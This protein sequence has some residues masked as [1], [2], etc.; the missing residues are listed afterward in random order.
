MYCKVFAVAVTLL[1]F[2]HVALAQ[3]LGFTIPG[4][5][6]WIDVTAF[7][8]KADSKVITDGIVTSGLATLSSNTAQFTFADVNKAITAKGAGVAGVDLVT[9]I[10]VVNTGVQVTLG[11]SS[12]LTSSTAT[13]RYST[14]NSTPIQ[15]AINAAP[16]TG[17]TIYFPYG[18]TGNYYIRSSGL[19]IAQT[20][21]GIKLQGECGGA[22]TPGGGATP[23]FTC[24]SI[25]TDQAISILTVGDTS[26]TP[27][28]FYAGLVVQ[29]LGFRDVSPSLTRVV[30]AIDLI[31][32][33][34]FNLTNIR[35]DNITAGYGILF[36][37]NGGH[38]GAGDYTQF[39]VVFH[40]QIY[41]TKFPIQ[42][43]GLTS[44]INL[45]G[46]NL[47]CYGNIPPGAASI[48]AGSIGIDIGKTHPLT[49]TTGGEWGVFGTHVLD[50]ATGV[51]DYN[52]SVMQWF[53]V[54][55]IVSGSR[56]GTTGFVVDGDTTGRAGGVLIGGSINNFDTDIMITSFPRNTKILASVTQPLTTALNIDSAALPSTLILTATDYT[57]TT[58]I[59]SQIPTDVTIPQEGLPATPASG[60]RTLYVDSTS[61]DLTVE[62]SDATTTDLE[63]NAVLIFSCTSGFTSSGTALVLWPAS[64]VTDCHQTGVLEI[65]VPFAGTLRNL[66]VNAN[67]GGVNGSSGV[68]TL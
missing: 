39:G 15:N 59:G 16:A 7:G 45:Y 23:P 30:G 17:A 65:P 56:T 31:N 48:I 51:Y 35:I 62:K 37:G 13:A 21:P 58:A 27:V 53:G 47:G 36:D 8:A 2:S 28:K 9:T 19:K 42:T 43:R 49:T 12:S 3:G 4:T 44:E 61:S 52:N 41:F 11:A 24:A 5:N 25:V 26:A 64:N 18:G 63:H 55:E 67:V 32:T 14:D 50:C 68:V 46:G 66:R 10:S 33:E 6:P 38:A 60:S 34:D 20:Q 40:P 57:G 22:S 29:D 54:A 1:I